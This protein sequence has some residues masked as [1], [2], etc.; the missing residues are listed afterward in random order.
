MKKINIGT[1]IKDT[2]GNTLECVNIDDIMY[3]MKYVRQDGSLSGGSVFYVPSH[4]KGLEIL[5]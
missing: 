5:N 3:E 2:I 1:R 4:F